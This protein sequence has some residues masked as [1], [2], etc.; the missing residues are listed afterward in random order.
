VAQTER[1]A[2]RRDIVSEEVRIFNVNVRVSTQ[3][4]ERQIVRLQN[5]KA[6]LLK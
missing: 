5:K 4:A 3:F 1:A 2:L 6:K